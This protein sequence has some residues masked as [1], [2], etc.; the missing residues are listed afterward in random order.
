[1]FLRNDTGK[2]SPSAEMTC[3]EAIFQGSDAP[4]RI[5]QGLD[6]VGCGEIAALEGIEPQEPA[7]LPRLN[8]A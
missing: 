6:A 2:G 8:R 3:G 5:F 7:L 1:M 4:L